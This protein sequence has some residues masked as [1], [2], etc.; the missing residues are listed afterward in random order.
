MV[1][2]SLKPIRDRHS[3]PSIAGRICP[4]LPKV[5]S[6]NDSVAAHRR[7]MI[8]FSKSVVLPRFRWAEFRM[9]PWIERFVSFRRLQ[10]RLRSTD[11]D[12][13]LFGTGDAKH[14]PQAIDDLIVHHDRLQW[15]PDRTTIRIGRETEPISPAQ[16][17][18]A[19]IVSWILI[20]AF[21]VV[22][23]KFHTTRLCRP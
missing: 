1:G 21:Q 10:Q 15:G 18:V 16:E 14:I 3:D 7:R 8:T 4:D 23:T 17:I 2:I 13:S 22:L 6:W 19:L 12:K 11:F 9:L 20:N 5:R